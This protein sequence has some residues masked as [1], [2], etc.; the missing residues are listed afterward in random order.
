MAEIKTNELGR[1][2]LG[3]LFLGE[4]PPSAYYLGAGTGVMP[5][6][7][8][9]V[10]S[11]LTEVTGPGYARMLLT[12]GA[13]DFP[14]LSLGSSGW[15][16]TSLFKRFEADGAWDEI[17]Y[18]FLCDAASGTVGQLFAMGDTDT[19]Q[20]T[21]GDAFDLAYQHTEFTG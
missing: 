15:S 1:V 9:T 21:A 13:T 5:T 10:L 19:F 2:V 20:A 16:L 6:D 8:D 17:T 7:P 18:V 11:D 12:P 14:S 3:V 4:E